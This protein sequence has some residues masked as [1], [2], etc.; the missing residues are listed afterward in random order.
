MTQ[1]K[2]EEKEKQIVYLYEQGKTYRKIAE[3]L[4]VSPSY[5]SS[6]IKKSRGEDDIGETKTVSKDTQARILF[7]QSKTPSEV[8][9]S[10][11]LTVEE[12]ERIYTEYWK[13]EG[14]HDLYNAYKGG[15]KKNIPS[16]LKL[17]E[18]MKDKEISE[19]QILKTLESSDKFLSLDA[20]VEMQA[21]KIESSVARN[22][23]LIAENEELLHEK[24]RLKNL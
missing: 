21:R 3:E 14:L 1:T 5:I 18:I 15:I 24:Q 4:R 23:R 12:V 13:L 19:K 2:R 20:L 16:F 8:A 10:L 22:S 17:Y 7:A 11:D 9:D 6:I